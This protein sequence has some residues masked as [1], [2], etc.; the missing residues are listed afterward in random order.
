MPVRQCR[1]PARV[2]ADQPLIGAGRSWLLLEPL[3]LERLAGDSA[4]APPR[5][6][7]LYGFLRAATAVLASAAAARR[8]RLGWEADSNEPPA[9]AAAVPASDPRPQGGTDGSASRDGTSSRGGS[10]RAPQ[11]TREQGADGGIDH[12]KSG[13]TAVAAEQRMSGGSCASAC[14]SP[15]LWE[16]LPVLMW[17]YANWHQQASAA[18]ASPSCAA[19]GPPGGQD[20]EPAA[21]AAA[22]G[23]NG[24]AARTLPAAVDAEGGPGLAPVVDL[25][26]L[27]PPLLP[28]LVLAL[29]S[30]ALSQPRLPGGTATPAAAPTARG[31]P[32]SH[33]DAIQGRILTSL[34]LLQASP[35]SPLV[36]ALRDRAT[37]VDATNP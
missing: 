5:H 29:G 19:Q 31:Q 20:A 16:A 32:A 34:L 2:C 35:V 23:E 15:A 26:R 1:R 36:A 3:L 8:S 25:L 24:A 13:E 22:G 6:R 17:L 27:L 30:A 18:Q 11:D 7:A 28:Q 14:A 9:A 4:A 10:G 33:P 21:A 12:R 37:I